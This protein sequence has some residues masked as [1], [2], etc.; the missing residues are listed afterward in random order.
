MYVI[1][2][3]AVGSPWTQQGTSA[4]RIVFEGQIRDVMD[5]VY[6]CAMS[7]LDSIAGIVMTRHRV[8]PFLDQLAAKMLS[9]MAEISFCSVPHLGL[10]ASL[11]SKVLS[12]LQASPNGC[13]CV[14]SHM[15]CY[16]DAIKIMPLDNSHPMALWQL[17]DLLVGKL[18]KFLSAAAS[19]LPSCRDISG[20]VSKLL[21]YAY[22]LLRHPQVGE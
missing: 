4:S 11:N 9:T 10:A 3:F 6:V 1:R 19:C 12:A 13:F 2:K 8:I 15:P 14:L 16:T 17:D 5:K 20:A 21:P 18:L 22:L 7:I